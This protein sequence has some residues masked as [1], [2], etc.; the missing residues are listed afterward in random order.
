MLVV[1]ILK[2]IYMIH[3]SSLKNHGLLKV[4]VIYFNN[5]KVG[6]AILIIN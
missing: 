1:Y 5:E 3:Q 4:Y 2:A 6:I